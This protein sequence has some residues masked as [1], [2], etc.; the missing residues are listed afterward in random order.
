MRY[1]FRTLVIMM[2]LAPPLLAGAMVVGVDPFLLFLATG[3]V[4]YLLFGTVVAWSV[5]W[6]VEKILPSQKSRD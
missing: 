1:S 4:A 6:F 3:H 5:A 2:I